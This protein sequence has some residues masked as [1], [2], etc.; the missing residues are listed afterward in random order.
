MILATFLS[1][2]TFLLIYEPVSLSKFNP[3]GEPFQFIGIFSNC[4]NSSIF[5]HY[6]TVKVCKKSIDWVMEN[7]DFIANKT[8]AL[9]K[10]HISKI[11]GGGPSIM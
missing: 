2:L 6:Q 10:K 1:A 9:M 7:K 4:K 3:G 11:K 8:I 5:N